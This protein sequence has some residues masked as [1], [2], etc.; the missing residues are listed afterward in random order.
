MRISTLTLILAAVPWAAGAAPSIPAVYFAQS[1]VQKAS[2]PYPT[3]AGGR[4][5][6]IKAH[7]V[8]P[9]TP[10]SP[11]VSAL[12]QL[13]GSSLSISLTGPATL[14]ASIPDGPGVVQHSSANTFTGTIPAAWIKPGLVVTVNAGSAQTLVNNLNIGAP[15]HLI[16]TMTD[17]HFFGL[18][19]GTYPVGWDQEL[20]AKL[21]ISQMTLNRTASDVV[22]PEITMPPRAGN[23][24]VKVTSKEEY[25]AL[26][27]I[28]FD[29]E[30]DV[31]TAWNVA[32]RRAA[33]RSGGYSLYYLNKYGV[34]SEGVGGGFSAVGT[35]GSGVNARGIL[36]HELGHALNL[37]HWG[38]NAAYPYKGTM[39]GITAPPTF[40][41]AHAGPTWAYHLPG[42][43]FIP[44]TVQPGNAGSKPVGTYK[45]DPMEGGGQGY[46]E[47]GF[48]F[49][50]FSD[51][52][53]AQ[54][55]GYMENTVVAWNTDLNSYAK[56]NSTTKSYST[57]VSNDDVKYPKLRNQSV[58]S[59]IASV[60][61][62]T[63][64][65]SIA[66]PPIGPYTAGLIRLFDP[67]VAA[68]RTAASGIFAPAGGCDVCLRVTQGGLTKTYML[69]ASYDPAA[70]PT[71]ASSLVTEGINLPAANGTVTRVEL[72]L[73]PNAQINGLPPSPEVLYTWTP[74]AAPTPS[75][76][77]FAVNPA[78]TSPYTISMTAVTG[79]GN[80]D[81]NGKIEYLF[82]EISG[83][84]GSNSSGWQSSP[85]F[86]ADSLQP[87]TTYQFTVKMRSGVSKAESAASAALSATTPA[88]TATETMLTTG[89]TNSWE[90]G[91]WT[92]GIPSGN[93][94]VRIKPGITASM[95]AAGSLP[96]WSGTLTLDN[97][98]GLYI[99]PG[100][101]GTLAG[102]TS[103]VFREGSILYDIFNTDLNMPAITLVNGGVMFNN[104]GVSANRTRN[105]PQPIT[106]TGGFTTTGRSGGTYRFQNAN[107]FTGAYNIRANQ[108][109]TVEFAAA[110]SAGAGDVTV[111]P[112]TADSP[113]TYS[114]VIRLAAH[115]VFASSCTLTLNGQGAN[116]TT[117]PS[118]Y[119]GE[120]TRLDMG[121]FSASVSR[122]I[123]DNVEMPP[124]QYTGT[125][126]TQDWIDGT[127]TLTVTGVIGY[128][129]WIA[130]Y[131]YL[132]DFDLVTD[133]PD[134]DGLKNLLEYAF[135]TNPGAASNAALAYVAGGAVTT[136]GAPK[137]LNLS[138]GSNPDFR[139][140]FARRKDRVAAGL[141][142]TVQFSAG[143]DHWVNG[144]VTPTVITGAGAANPS[145]VEVVSV[146]F[147][148]SI[149]V[150]G[151]TK[152]PTFFRVAVTHDP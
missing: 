45:V 14:P 77:A 72:L 119:T 3:L 141:T 25:A 26:T 22:F 66:Y 37:P 74:A 128:D 57:L 27:G 56:W 108:R 123:I 88:G 103:I 48:Y 34:A 67:T 93:I 83:N 32:L 65:V 139:A 116:G 16:M 17:I 124:G 47:A 87:N 9:L 81:F 24:A 21:P 28:A 61:G 98:S 91:T 97:A 8:D 30:N 40:N 51:Y 122:L 63:P 73:T 118:T 29:G 13:A 36:L 75:T 89:G 138:A 38:G 133:D 10:A 129:A 106:G 111:F 52:S 50:H 148:P 60:S 69:A 7:V 49:N 140:I 136:P 68:D 5:A 78:A 53:V 95:E 99:S 114:A 11:A 117:I 41:G 20:A 6:L 147:P 71:S 94:N 130:S 113:N 146:S 64:D 110:N 18:S 125:A 31:A 96:A 120:K 4:S 39:H 101:H 126:A 55:R 84:L 102:A 132:H 85:T 43:R 135:G 12:L 105:F 112:T 90:T 70:D 62:A 58:I 19:P 142:Y 82:T 80:S 76:A 143:L 131:P 149:M 23:A 15:T 35:S 134:S 100:F 2:D 104:G 59:L 144:T 121:A 152:K 54:M 1:H 127:G 42:S 46:Q 137:I 145:D 92:H 150:P 44:C 107:T 86:I 151:G 33:G 115:N 109:H 79:A